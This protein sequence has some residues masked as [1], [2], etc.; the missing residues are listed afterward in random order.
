MYKTCGLQVRISLHTKANNHQSEMV[1]VGTPYA[2]ATAEADALAQ[3]TTW[4]AA[5]GVAPLLAASV[6]WERTKEEWARQENDEAWEDAEEVFQMKRNG[7]THMVTAWFH[8]AS[9][10]VYQKVKFH[11]G[12]PSRRKIAA[13]LRGS[14]DQN[15]YTIAAL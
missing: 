3:V 12:Y 11:T 15:D 14:H 1:N 4:L 10:E 6:S 7:A 9:G 13:M 8:P 5:H 2:E